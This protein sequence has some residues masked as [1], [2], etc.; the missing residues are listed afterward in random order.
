[1]AGR[2]A[3]RPFLPGLPMPRQ[4]SR[5]RRSAADDP[6]RVACLVQAAYYVATGVWPLVSP[7]SFQA[8]TGPKRDVWLVKTVGVL[9][10]VVGASLAVAAGREG[11]HGTTSI[12]VLAVGSALGLAAVDVVFVARGRISRIYL[13]DAAAELGLVS[14]WLAPART[15]R[16]QDGAS[17]ASST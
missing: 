14:V 6:R 15:R 5:L 8:V 12:R 17:R 1:M 7:R 4:V 2:A 3:T 9:V 10:G 11:T 13:A 16:D